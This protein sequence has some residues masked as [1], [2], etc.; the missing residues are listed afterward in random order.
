MGVG[1]VPCIDRC[2]HVI[3]KGELNGAGRGI[4]WVGAWVARTEGLPFG[5]QQ[6]SG[7]RGVVQ[8][9]AVVVL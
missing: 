3:E 6:D 4:L 5:D 1:F 2:E 7:N 8:K 9:I